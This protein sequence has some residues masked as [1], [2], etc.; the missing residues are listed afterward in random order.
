MP[1]F[2]SLSSPDKRADV[3]NLRW[4]LVLAA[5][6]VLTITQLS[7]HAA[8]ILYWVGNGSNNGTW[9]TSTNNWN[10][11]TSAGPANTAWSNSTSSA[12]FD[13]NNT[14]NVTVSPTQSPSI[15]FNDTNPTINVTAGNVTFSGGTL[16][17]QTNYYGAG[18]TIASGASVTVTS[19][20]TSSKPFLYQF[21]DGY[22]DTSGNT[23]IL[24]SNAGPSNS[25]Y[26]IAGGGTWNLGTVTSVSTN[27][28]FL[29]NHLLVLQGSNNVFEGNGTLDS[30][31]VN[32]NNHNGEIEWLSGG[33]FAAKGGSLTVNIG[34]SAA[35]LE[36]GVT[37]F[38]PSGSPLIFGSPYADSLVDFKNPLDM[39]GTT[40]TIQVIGNANAGNAAKIDG[41]ISD[42]GL[43]KTGTGTLTLANT[44]TYSGVTN[45]NAGTLLVDGSIA[46]SSLTTVN[47]TGT[48]GGHGTVGALTIASGGTVSPGD[49]PGILT[50]G[51]TTLASG[52]NY[53]WQMYDANGTAGTGFDQLHATGALTLNAGFNLNLWSLSSVSPDSNGNAL[54]FNPLSGTHEWIIAIGDGGLVSGDLHTIAY[55]L[56]H[57]NIFTSANN[58]TGG[59]T[60]SLD[61]GMFSLIQGGTPGNP[62][63]NPHDVDLVFSVVP[64]PGSIVLMLFGL[65][66]IWRLLR[67]RHPV[68]VA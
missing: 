41:V 37:T 47:S 9:D 27:S 16:N 5:V 44:N 2:Q 40:Q 50:S 6:I 18:F 53:N 54:N 64:E 36:F 57:I 3:G 32:N 39:A 24:S 51:A 12:E 26:V 34:G 62:D 17:L 11:T 42:G 13:A 7:G 20:V 65:A 46:N 43:I 49:S 68:Q 63:T 33:G 55:D 48:I 61:G 28:G 38:V 25:A 22:L 45:V 35:K 15:S 52:G 8:T 67:R 58:G 14:Y 60:N 56:S 59:F 30:S 4:P 29:Y 31:L 10:T 23:G 66:G 19:A 1:D 21:G